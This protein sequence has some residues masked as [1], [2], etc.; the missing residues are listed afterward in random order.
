MSSRGKLAAVRRVAEEP[1]Y[2][3]ELIRTIGSGPDLET[4]LRG[5][6]RLVTEATA[7]HACFIYFLEQG[8]LEL[9]AA[10]RLYEHLEGKVA[11]PVGE[12]LTGWVAS[13][14]Q[15]AWIRENAIEDPRVRR[16]YFPEMGDDVYQSLVSVPIFARAG[17]VIGVITLHAEAPHEFVRADVELLE[18]TASLVA[19]AIENASLYEDATT[20]VAILEALSGLSQRIASAGSIAEVL[21]ELTEGIPD[22][23]HVGRCAV[24]LAQPQG[25]LRL[26]TSYPA[27]A[28]CESLDASVAW[29]LAGGRD[30]GHRRPQASRDL[31]AA[32]WGTDV[33]GTVLILPLVAGEVRLGVIAALAAPDV[34]DP[35]TV[36]AAIGAHAAVAIR[37]HQLIEG[38]REENL[39]KDL[40]QALANPDVPLTEAESAA[41]RLGCDLEATHLLV[42]VVPWR[43]GRSGPKRGESRARRA[44]SRALAWSDATSQIE[45]RLAARFP[46]LLADRLEGSLRALVPTGDDPEGAVEALRSMAWGTADR[47]DALSVGVSNPCRGAAAFARGF[48]EAASAADVGG[49]IRGSPGVTTYE[50]LGPYRYVL[51][52]ER[53]FHDR[54]QERLERLVGYD[55]RRGTELLD[56]LER[57]LDERGNVVGTARTL[58]IHPNTLRQ[59]LAR[60][61]RISGLDLERE[62]WLSLAVATKVVKLRRMRE[63]AG[64][65]G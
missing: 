36:L 10:S 41:A 29:S 14:R 43:A 16:A 40:F 37:Q 35:E 45:A 60:I 12:G 52:S 11:I 22:V 53:G 18:H 51:S 49:L 33:S 5:V 23:L 39:V 42:H 47:P 59:R 64:E 20:R 19:G 26:S 15:S 8:R 6:V 65:E 3:H 50:D 25:D 56:T 34:P 55:R 13:T 28:A 9:R 48:E 46:G 63:T 1:S 62:D 54:Y 27:G 32:V 58:Y 4:I 44:G 17:E 24:Y 30:K 57:Y 21:A 2:L 38:L 61:A 7:C 31:A